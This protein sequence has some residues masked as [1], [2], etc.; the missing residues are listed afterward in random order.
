MPSTERVRL[1]A[2][3]SRS[4]REEI[5]SD[6]RQLQGERTYF[7][8][9]PEASLEAIVDQYP[10]CCVRLRHD[11]LQLEFGNSVGFV[12]LPDLGRLEIVSGKWRHQDFD[13]MLA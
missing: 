3:V 7:V 5:S 13:Q 2:Q 9:G 11:L 6:V 8:E 10:D 4:T 1:F 12:E